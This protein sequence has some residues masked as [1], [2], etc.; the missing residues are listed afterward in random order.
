MHA[1]LEGLSLVGEIALKDGQS[2]VHAHVVVGTS[3][4]SAYGGHPVEGHVRPTLEVM[5]VESPKFLQ[6]THD[7]ESGL[8]LIDL[9][10]SSEEAA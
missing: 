5:R 8:A 3:D 9:G 2:M 7:K 10:P 4:G 6:R 1:Q